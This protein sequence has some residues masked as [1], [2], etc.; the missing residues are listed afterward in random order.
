LQHFKEA[1]GQETS[2]PM[3]PLHV[4]QSSAGH[5][6]APRSS[7]LPSKSHLHSK[8]VP[9]TKYFKKCLFHP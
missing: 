8:H 6:L 5:D 4:R 9:N 7:T 3:V 1:V 2:L